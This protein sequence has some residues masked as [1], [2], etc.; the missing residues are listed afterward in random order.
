[1]PDL[2]S[3]VK[4]SARRKGVLTELPKSHFVSSLEVQVPEESLSRWAIGKHNC[5]TSR[6]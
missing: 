2:F 4:A 1:M 3:K 6:I 5:L